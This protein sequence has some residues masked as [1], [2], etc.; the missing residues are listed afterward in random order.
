MK[1]QKETIKLKKK[2]EFRYHDVEVKKRN[3]K[4]RIVKHPAYVFLEESNVYIY[5]SI[6]HSNNVDGC[7]VIKLRKNP[8]PLD[9][10]DSYRVVEIKTGTKETFGRKLIN[11]EMDPLD[12]LDIRKEYKK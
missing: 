6:T 8:N 2:K 11:W 12:D 10:S 5:V 1:N 3:G 9:D 4:T 7:L